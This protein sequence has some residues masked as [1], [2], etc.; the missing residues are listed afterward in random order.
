MLHFSLKMFHIY[1]KFSEWLTIHTVWVHCVLYSA[2][3]QDGWNFELEWL[4]RKV[5]VSDLWYWRS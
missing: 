3:W 4:W 5:T 2:G 1:L